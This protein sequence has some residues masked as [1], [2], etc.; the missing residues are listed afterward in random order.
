[1]RGETQL[2]DLSRREAD[3]AL[4]FGRPKQTSLL[5]R[6]LGQVRFGLYASDQYL[7]RRG[8]PRN[9]AALVEHDFVGFEAALDDLEQVRWIRRAVPEPRYVLRCNGTTI[10]ALACAAGHGIALLPDYVGA[11]EPRLRRLL[12]RLLGPTRELWFVTHQ[13]LRGNARVVAFQGF[14]SRAL[15]AEASGG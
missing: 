6:R 10:Q 15:S 2:L 7:E 8:L 4:R 13:D 9:L 5:A 1:L 14:A 11:R 3:V 12:P